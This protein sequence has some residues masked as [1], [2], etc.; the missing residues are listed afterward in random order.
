MSNGQR[1]R[2]RETKCLLSAEKGF[3]GGFSSSSRG[4]R[5]FVQKREKNGRGMTV[6]ADY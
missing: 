2:I 4:I 5:G 6:V 3:E 1:S